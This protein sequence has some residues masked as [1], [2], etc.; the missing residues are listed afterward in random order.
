MLVDSYSALDAVL[1]R[2]QQLPSA[3]SKLTGSSCS[4]LILTTAVQI[5]SMHLSKR[6]GLAPAPP[7]TA[8]SLHLTP[9]HLIFRPTS[10]DE[11]WVSTSAIVGSAPVFLENVA[12]GLHVPIL[13]VVVD[14]RR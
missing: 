14:A 8:G 13:A 2:A 1:K 9:H 12:G 6:V 7:P 4:L 11:L 5:R 10:G 3:L